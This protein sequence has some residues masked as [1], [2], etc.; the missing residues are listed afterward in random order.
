M[1]AVVPLHLI[2]LDQTEIHFA[3]QR[4]GLQCVPA[5]FARHVVLSHA[6]KLLVDSIGEPFEGLL[7]TSA[8]SMQELGDFRWRRPDH[9]IA[10]VFMEFAID[11]TALNHGASKY[12]RGCSKVSTAYHTRTIDF[13]LFSRFLKSP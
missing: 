7:I 4:R 10:Q 11:V 8:P 1:G 12:A 13:L 2:D 3:D 6:V 9:E 5:S